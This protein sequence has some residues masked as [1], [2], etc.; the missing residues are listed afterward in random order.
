M[1]IQLK[2]DVTINCTPGELA[3]FLKAMSDE[4]ASEPTTGTINDLPGKVNDG[5][6]VFKSSY[7][8]TQE[9]LKNRVIR[10]VD[11][12]VDWFTEG[13]KYTIMYDKQDGLFVV[14]DSGNLFVFSDN[15]ENEFNYIILW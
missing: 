13:N 10:V 2:N 12:N 15:N 7:K 9:L 6:E 14:D 11:S 8:P 5:Q 3:R 1:L 4:P